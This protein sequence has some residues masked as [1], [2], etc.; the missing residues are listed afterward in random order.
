MISRMGGKGDFL[1][2]RSYDIP[3]YDSY[4]Y[5]FRG[6]NSVSTLV[7]A[8]RA[9]AMDPAVAQ[10]IRNADAIFIGGGAQG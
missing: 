2:L 5:D 4:I 3:G 1:A 6:V 9:A 10:I 7:I 8:N